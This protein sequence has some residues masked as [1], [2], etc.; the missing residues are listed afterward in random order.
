[1]ADAV[2]CDFAL[3][4]TGNENRGFFFAGSDGQFHAVG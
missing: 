4:F 2:A 3:V 1:M